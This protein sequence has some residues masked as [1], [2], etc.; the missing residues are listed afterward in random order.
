[1]RGSER[2]GRKASRVARRKT[3]TPRPPSYQHVLRRRGRLL[4]GRTGCSGQ[5][6]GLARCEGPAPRRAGVGGEAGRRGR[7]GGQ[8]G[9]A[10]AKEAAAAQRD[11][12]RLAGAG[13]LGQSAGAV[14]GGGGRGGGAGG[15]EGQAAEQGERAGSHRECGSARPERGRV[16]GWGGWVGGWVGGDPTSHPSKKTL[17]RVIVTGYPLLPSH[18]TLIPSISERKRE[19]LCAHSVTVRR[20]RE[21]AA[22]RQSGEGGGWGRSARAH[23][24]AHKGEANNGAR[25]A[26]GLATARPPHPP[27]MGLD[28]CPHRE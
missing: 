3:R 12:S 20:H 26:P 22:G 7:G 27:S 18:L 15:G 16:G 9:A 21:R 2:A 23:C 25:P 14:H 6:S 28:M 5:A 10:S 4:R 13:D 11:G 17:A 19:R 1:M 24:A 8:A